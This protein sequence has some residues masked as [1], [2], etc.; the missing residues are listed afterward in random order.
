M[1]VAWSHDHMRSDIEFAVSFCSC[2]DRFNK[3][4]GREIAK[5]RLDTGKSDFV[6]VN[7]YKEITSKYVYETLMKDFNDGNFNWNRLDIDFPDHAAY[8]ELK[9]P[10]LAPEMKWTID[11][12]LISQ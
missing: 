4:V 6:P 8:N 1:T 9:E 2:K 3:K 7:E 12:E 10:T 11:G 5:G